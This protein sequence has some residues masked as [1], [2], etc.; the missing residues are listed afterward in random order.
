MN[1]APIMVSTV[2]MLRTFLDRKPAGY[3]A[4]V[5]LEKARR[6]VGL[7]DFQ[8]LAPQAGQGRLEVDGPLLQVRERIEAQLLMHLVM[9]EWVLQCPAQG[10]GDLELRL[11]HTGAIRRS[12]LRWQGP[13]PAALEAAVRGSE[14]LLALDFKRVQLLRREGLWT[15]TIE[16]MGASEVVNRMPAFR[17]YIAVSA[18]QREHLIQTVNLFHQ[19]LPT[20]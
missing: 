19:L 8:A 12:G 17:R 1:R 9:C 10:G 13:V 15:L 16:H 18:Q 7:L 14:A 5:T 2:V 6:N 3:R 4:G 20:L 11:H